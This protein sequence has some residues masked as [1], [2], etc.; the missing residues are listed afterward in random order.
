MPGVDGNKASKRVVVVDDE[1]GNG[2]VRF[3]GLL[4]ATDSTGFGGDPSAAVDAL[5]GDCGGASFEVLGTLSNRNMRSGTGFVFSGLT[6][7]SFRR[8]LG[9]AK[10]KFGDPVRLGV[11]CSETLL[12]DCEAK[13]GVPLFRRTDSGSFLVFD[14][15]LPIDF[16]ELNKRLCSFSYEKVLHG[17]CFEG[18]PTF[19]DSPNGKYPGESSPTRAFS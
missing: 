17:A 2:I 6:N 9:V 15:G 13:W 19:S 14:R 5:F 7:S 1:E 10:L 16:I 3:V 8:L 4:C 11:G 18:L 12:G